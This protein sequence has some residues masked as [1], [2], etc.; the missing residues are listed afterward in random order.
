MLYAVTVFTEFFVKGS[1]EDRNL[2]F[3]ASD[4]AFY[5][6]SRFLQSKLNISMPSVHSAI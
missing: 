3:I 4:P 2:T 6:V 5:L 1:R